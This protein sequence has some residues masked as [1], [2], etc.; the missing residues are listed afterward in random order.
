MLHAIETGTTS[1]TDG[2]TD[3]PLIDMPTVPTTS[4]NV[5]NVI[6]DSRWESLGLYQFK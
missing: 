3:T 6:S 5:N 4:A 1:I 2:Y